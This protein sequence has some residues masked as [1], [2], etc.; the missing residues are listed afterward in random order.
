M[1]PPPGLQFAFADAGADPGFVRAHLD[2]P[3][4]EETVYT[5]AAGERIAS[6]CF[7]PGAPKLYFVSGNDNT[8]WRVDYINGTWY[9][10]FPV[11]QHQ[12]Y[13]RCVRFVH[14][15]PGQHPEDPTEEWHLFFSEASGAGG[16][17]VI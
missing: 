10:E 15:E 13:V 3:P 8:L 9:E 12:T 2:A 16:D 7:H 17:G 14:D 1:E 11:Y 4:G 6:F 5:R